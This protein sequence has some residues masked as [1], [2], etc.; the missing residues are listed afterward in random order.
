MIHRFLV[1][2]TKKYQHYYVMLLIL[3]DYYHDW[4]QNVNDLLD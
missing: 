3:F 4:N 2:I 1:K